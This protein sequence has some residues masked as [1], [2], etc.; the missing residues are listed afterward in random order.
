MGVRKRFTAGFPPEE[1]ISLCSAHKLN[2]GGVEMMKIKRAAALLLCLAVL[3]PAAGCT[4]QETAGDAGRVIME[5]T[6]AEWTQTVEE[7][8]GI[9][10]FGKPVGTVRETLREKEG[11]LTVTFEIDDEMTQE[12]VDGYAQSVWRA[13]EKAGAGSNRNSGGA[14]YDDMSEACRR[15]EPFDYY[16]WYYKIDRQRFRVGIY[17]TNMEENRPGGLVLRIEKW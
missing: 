13:C 6:A 2:A 7:K 17:S 3:F 9:S 4:E 10:E 11:V 16:I 12:L 14:V 5:K 1:V 8:C 15:Q